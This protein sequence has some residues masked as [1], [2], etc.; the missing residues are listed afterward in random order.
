[1]VIWGVFAVCVDAAKVCRQTS[2]ADYNLADADATAKCKSVTLLFYTLVAYVV[3]IVSMSIGIFI[4][5]HAWQNT[6]CNV[7]T[8]YVDR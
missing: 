1:M 5:K 7:P 8:Q 3:M 6:H 4:Y 2:E